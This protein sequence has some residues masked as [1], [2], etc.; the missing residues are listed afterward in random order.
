MKKTLLLPFLTLLSACGTGGGSNNVLVEDRANQPEKI[1]AIVREESNFN[2][3][4]ETTANNT[5]N[6]GLS[7]AEA[8]AIAEL[9]ANSTKFILYFSYDDFGI[10]EQNTREIIKHA[11]FMRDN[12]GVKLRLEG[13]ADERGTREYNL[14][15]GENRA[16]S[17]KEVLGLY[18]GL[19]S[20]TQI[21][22]YGEEN[23][24][25]DEHDEAAWAKNRRV[26]FIYQ[27]TT[28]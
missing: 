8:K 2:W 6:T 19:E 1:D 3:R 24:I 18:K 14:A 7:V 27:S 28:K 17:I 26:E 4:D 9:K 23:P 10:S 15:L 22:S 25:V 20:R 5:S 21:I 12:P 16:I 11:N 13:H